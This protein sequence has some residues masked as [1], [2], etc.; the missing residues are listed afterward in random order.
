MLNR[1][2]DERGSMMVIFAVAIPLLLIL[3]T[4]SIDVGNWFTHKRHLQTQADA[5]AFAAGTQF[6]L[7]CN[8]AA[9]I[10]I[11]NT[12]RQY[13]GPTAAGTPTPSFNPQVSGTPSANLH[14]ILNAVNYWGQGNDTEFS[15]GGH[16]CA[17]GYLDVKMTEKDLPWFF[18]WVGSG[19]V[20]TINTEARVKFTQAQ[21]EKGFIPLGLPNPKIAK[22][23]ATIQVCNG[24]GLSTLASAALKDSGTVVN[25]LNIWTPVNGGGIPTT[26]PI[27]VP[28]WSQC[29]GKDYMAFRVNIEISGSPLVTPS[30]ANCGTKFVDCYDTIEQRDYKVANDPIPVQFG[31]VQLQDVNCTPGT[32]YW[33]SGTSTTLPCTFGINAGVFWG[34][35]NGAGF[36]ATAT[37]SSGGSSST[38][39]GPGLTGDGA[40]NGSGLSSGDGTPGADPQPVPIAY[41]WKRTSGTWHGNTCNN[42]GGNKCKGSGTLTVH[43]ANAD[44]ANLI[45][46]VTATDP[47]PGP[48]LGRLLDSVDHTTFP[49][50]INL[51]V[52]MTSKFSPGQRQVLRLGSSQG[53]QSLVCDPAYTNGQTFL[54]IYKGCNP[55]YG[56]NNLNG[57]VGNP[58]VTP[59][60][61]WEP[62]PGTGSFFFYP[63][64]GN[65]S[66]WYCMPTEPGLRA[67]QVADGIAARTGNCTNIQSKSCSKTKC[68]NPNNYQPGVSYDPNNPA[69]SR[70][71]KIYLIPSGALNTSSGNDVVEVVGFAGFYITGWKGLGANADPCGGDDIPNNNGEIAGRFVTLIDPPNAVPNPGS[72]CDPNSIIPCT[73]VL[74]R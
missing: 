55:L 45:A 47:T 30:L 2:R 72:T 69:N 29:S 74:V 43:R 38:L 11:E 20:P 48:N 1:L 6:K 50:A 66:T 70:V 65:T 61:S 22:A 37:A 52:G 67:S 33:S 54:M 71:V 59:A 32:P 35:R 28:S 57:T 8:S 63:Q 73:V 51:T 24:S 7:P 3:G 18:N 42:T 34:D 39:T 27:V 14:G 13:A 41:T 17:A 56:I 31:N 49:S 68:L 40:L 58:P 64:S 60:I 12:A 21:A 25:G 9:D 19:I 62:C 10:A 4:F 5:A 36:S 15:D 53:N 44:D 46:N 16:P 23:T 26:I